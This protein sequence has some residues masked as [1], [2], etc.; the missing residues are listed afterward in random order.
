MDVSEK[1]RC[2]CFELHEMMWPCQHIMA[3]DDRDGKDFMR[4]FVPCWLTLS[5]IKLYESK[6]P[7]FLS[8]NLELIDACFP[9]EV[10]KKGRHQVV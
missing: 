5:L 7:I 1:P 8:N 3:W 2:M 4:H 6:F 9:P 10:V